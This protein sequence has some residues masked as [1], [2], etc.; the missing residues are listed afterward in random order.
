MEKGM[1]I[2]DVGVGVGRDSILEMTFITDDNVTKHIH[3]PNERLAEATKEVIK[4]IRSNTITRISI[5]SNVTGDFVKDQIKK[6]FPNVPI[7][8]TRF[9]R[10][11]VANG[12]GKL[13]V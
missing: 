12:G 1:L 11:M 13:N 9:V 2:L 3:G 5:S 10:R 8:K 4:F 7:G 6:K